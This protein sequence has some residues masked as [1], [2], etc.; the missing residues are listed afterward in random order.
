MIFHF[1]TIKQCRVYNVGIYPIKKLYEDF[2]VVDINNVYIQIITI[3]LKKHN[4]LSPNNHEVNNRHAAFTSKFEC[5]NNCKD[6]TKCRC[7]YWCWVCVDRSAMLI[8]WV[9]N[10]L[11]QSLEYINNNFLFSY[12]VLNKTAKGNIIIFKLLLTK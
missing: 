7:D 5:E 10:L 9:R 12:S 8:H 2:N 11:E 6:R 4:Q 1:N 3:Y